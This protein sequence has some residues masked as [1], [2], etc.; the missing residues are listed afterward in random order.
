MPILPNDVIQHIQS[1]LIKCEYCQRFFDMNHSNLC[2]SCKRSWC[3][4]CKRNTNFIG[5]SYHQLYIM[6]CK[7]CISKYKY[8]KMK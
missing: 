5:Y 7:Y 1:F 8:P 2:I 6:A 3:D 4:D